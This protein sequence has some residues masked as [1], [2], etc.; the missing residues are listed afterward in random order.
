MAIIDFYPLTTY[1]GEMRGKRIK[2]ICHCGKPFEDYVSNKRS[3]YC[4][5]PCYWE[6][7][8]FDNKYSGYWTGKLRSNETKQKISTT[9]KLH[10]YS[11]KGHKALTGNEHPFWKGEDVSYSGIHHWIARKLG[12][13]SICEHC[14][15]NGLSS[16]KIHW[17]NKSGMYLRN[18]TDWIRLCAKCHK[19]YDKK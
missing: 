16:K 17:A 15:K 3:K 9:K 4:S 11:T 7:R 8:K 12:K 14:G 10:P 5:L 6:A 2:T 18:T 13:P 19:K 1:N